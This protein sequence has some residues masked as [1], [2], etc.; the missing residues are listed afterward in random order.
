MYPQKL[1]MQKSQKDKTVLHG[2]DMD[3]GEKNKGATICLVCP[4]PCKN[5][6]NISATCCV[7]DF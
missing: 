1:K 6:K 2:C 5:F 7:D 3:I 4:P